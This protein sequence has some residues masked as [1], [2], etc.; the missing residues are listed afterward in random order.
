MSA[1]VGVLSGGAPG[2]WHCACC[3]WLYA[4]TCIAAG[5]TPCLPA[6]TTRDPSPPGLL[7]LQV[8]Q[9]M[10]RWIV[11]HRK[12]PRSSRLRRMV[13]TIGSFFVPLK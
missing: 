7:A 8:M 6:R 4:L 1:G 3:C 9:K 13:P 12:D 11:E 2:G 5:P 10:E